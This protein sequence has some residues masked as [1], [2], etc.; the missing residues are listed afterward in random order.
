MPYETGWDTEELKN[1]RNEILRLGI[2][3]R[4][5]SKWEQEKR[6]F[7]AIFQQN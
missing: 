7:I 5:I 3:G 2:L 1:H 4:F 6:D